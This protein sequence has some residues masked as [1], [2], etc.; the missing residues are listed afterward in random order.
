MLLRSKP[1]YS[2]RHVTQYR[3]VVL[4]EQWSLQQQQQQQQP[5]HQRDRDDEAAVKDRSN[6]SL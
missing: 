5:H 2:P 3:P 1:V 4:V 6:R